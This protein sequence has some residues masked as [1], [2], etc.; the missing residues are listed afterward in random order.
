MAMFLIFGALF[1]RVFPLGSILP[2]T[3]HLLEM[4]TLKQSGQ[5]MEYLTER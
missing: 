4:V 2:Y 1:P 3:I 5:S